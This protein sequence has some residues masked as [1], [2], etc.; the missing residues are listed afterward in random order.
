VAVVGPLTAPGPSSSP[1]SSTFRTS[2]LLDF[3]SIKELTAQT[4]HPP[5]NWP[6]VVVKELTDNSLD[7]C[8]EA[9]IAP[10]IA[11]R[12]G[13]HGITVIDNGPGLPPGVID[14]IL[15]F[16]VRVSSREAY[17]SPS[18]GAQGN[19]LMTLVAMPFCLDGKVGRVEI[20]AQG[21]RHRIT[22]ALEPIRQQPV[23]RH[24]R[25]DGLVKNGTRVTVRWPSS[26]IGQ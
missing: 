26:A 20:D 13:A 24:E 10:E 12:V 1:I 11:V 3:A 17:V 18:R 9:G 2:R 6:L 7:G 25:R 21:V 16:G 19:A 14:D 15:D 5:A 4:G 22:F 8:K 23:I